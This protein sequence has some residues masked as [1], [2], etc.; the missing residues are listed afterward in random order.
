MALK[1]IKAP[2]VEVSLESYE[3]INGG[4]DD[5]ERE[6]QALIGEEERALY[7]SCL[8]RRQR[9]VAELMAAGY[10]RQ[11]IAQMLTPKV[12]VQAVHQIILRIRKRLLK[13]AGI[14]IRK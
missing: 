12:C 13:R 6:V 5:D 8:T 10:K 4:F 7:I 1:Y 3:K 2:I 14:P 11:E 9:Q